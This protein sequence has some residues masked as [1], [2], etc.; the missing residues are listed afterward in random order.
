MAEIKA[1]NP[2]LKDAEAVYLL[3]RQQNSPEPFS[4]VCPQSLTLPL[5]LRKPVRVGK[6]KSNVFG[7]G[8]VDY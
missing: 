5:P 3:E 7:D 8:T 2:S 6:Y 1:R 4:F